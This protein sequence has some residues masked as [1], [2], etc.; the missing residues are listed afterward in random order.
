MDAPA[1]TSEAF[2]GAS[3]PTAGEEP[4]PVGVQL[5]AA[6]VAVAASVLVLRVLFVLARR[7][8]WAYLRHGD[9]YALRVAGFAKHRDGDVGARILGPTAR[10]ALPRVGSVIGKVSRVVLYPVKSSAGHAVPARRLDACGLVG[11][12][13][14]MVVNSTGL[15]RTARHI[16]GLQMITTRVDVDEDAGTETLTLGTKLPPDAEAPASIAIT[17]PLRRRG[18]GGGGAGAGAAPRAAANGGVA[19]PSSLPDCVNERCPN[20]GKAVVA[21]SL[22]YYRGRVVGFC[23]Q[24]CRDD[25]AAN[26]DSP[27][28][29]ETRAN[30][31]GGDTLVPDAP[32]HTKAVVPTG[33]K[34]Q[35]VTV[36]SGACDVED[37]GDEAGAFLDAALAAH[38]AH[39]VR[40]GLVPSTGK[41]Q[42]APQRGLRLVR[43]RDDL[44]SGARFTSNVPLLGSAAAAS[45]RTAL[46]DVGAM[47]LTSETSL[48]SLNARLNKEHAKRGGSASDAPRV[49]MARFRPNICVDDM[50]P[51]IEDRLATIRIG[52]KVT[53]QCFLPCG[54]CVMTTCDP[55]TGVGGFLVNGASKAEPLA[56][57]RRLRPGGPLGVV[58]VV[59][60]TQMGGSGG[61]APNFGVQC[62]VRRFA[63]EGGSDGDD[64]AAP[65][66]EV[67]KDT[68]HLAALGSVAVGDEVEV[69][70]YHPPDG[71]L[72]RLGTLALAVAGV[73]W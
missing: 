39:I 17:L 43:A 27:D 14:F 71:V 16:P 63:G 7:G 51:W 32:G 41:T 5:A 4:W 8:G 13:R 70:A 54:R 61:W 15:M 65:S 36:G 20:S 11:D 29:A 52:G 35:S 64:G 28:F 12:R 44:P 72:T 69:L 68:P 53:M 23:N 42:R 67:T 6:T 40:T 48:D 45:D 33:G 59:V 55:S 58:G 46:G 73:G 57:L 30:M 22:T 47:L 56:S 1:A 21:N 34:V 24:H 37:C 38:A 10:H 2:A 62:A 3:T 49:V 25:F 26:P 60:P 50:P 19:P 31:F 18:R 66:T 9:S